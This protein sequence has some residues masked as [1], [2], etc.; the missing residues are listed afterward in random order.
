MTE[1]STILK[2]TGHRPWELPEGRWQYYQEWNEAL[3]FHWKIPHE[4]LRKLVPAD[5]ELDE[6]EGENWISLVPFTMQKIRPRGLPAL[7]FI[8]DFHEINL[9]TY[10][11]K[12]NKPGV[13]FLNIEAE[14]HLSAW[15]S[16][17]ASGL[18]YEKANIQRSKGIYYSSNKN[19]GF[20]LQV[21]FNIEEPVLRKSA[22]ERWL[23]ERYCLYLEQ[24]DQLFRYEIHHQEWQLNAIKLKKLELKY[25]LHGIILEERK[26]DLIQYSSGVKV[27]AWAKKKIN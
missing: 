6:F 23:T 13:Y 4:I 25:Q 22:L 17:T 26:P 11:I 7:S 20:S 8:S 14:K 10:V 18:P 5:L 16:R 1:I 15:I 2:D 19:K 12:D 3:F 21:E 9:R 24:H 27:L